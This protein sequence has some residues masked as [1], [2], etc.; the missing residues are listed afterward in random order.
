MNYFHT[1]DEEEAFNDEADK[2]TTGDRRQDVKDIWFAA[3]DFFSKPGGSEQSEALPKVDLFEL[4]GDTEIPVFIE[5]ADKVNPG[6]HF[7]IPPAGTLIVAREGQ[8]EFFIPAWNA[9]GQGENV[10]TEPGYPKGYFE[11]ERAR[12]RL[13]VLGIVAK[14]PRYSDDQNSEKDTLSLAKEYEGWVFG[15]SE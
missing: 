9:A 6:V 11:E 10:K 7:S 14:M 15:D 3:R 13:S 2:Q 8:F 1:S 12:M 5:W 4:R